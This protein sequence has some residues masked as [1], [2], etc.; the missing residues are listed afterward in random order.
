MG[1]NTLFTGGKNNFDLSLFKTVA[2]GERKRLEFRWE[3]QNAF[4]HPQFTTPPARVNRSVR[5]LADAYVALS[6]FEPDLADRAD[7]DR[8]DQISKM[9]AVAEKALQLDPLLA[10]RTARWRWSTRAMRNGNSREKV[11]G[12]LSIWTPTDPCRA[13]S[14]PETFFCRSAA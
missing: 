14:L 13:L 3:A 7:Q 12:A 2:I 1:R 9:R 8:A 4:N 10:E 11:S 6:G 5:D